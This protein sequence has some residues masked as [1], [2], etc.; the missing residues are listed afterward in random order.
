MKNYRLKYAYWGWREFYA[1][2]VPK[3]G[4]IG[5]LV[6]KL[7]TLSGCD[8]IILVNSGRT[9]IRIALKAFKDQQPN[10]NTVLVPAYTCDAVVQ[11]VVVE[12]FNIKYIDV[13]KNLNMSIDI[14]AEEDFS[15]VLA[16]IAEHNYGYP[17]D[18]NKIAALGKTNDFYVIDDAAQVQ[19]I[20]IDGKPMGSFA[21]AGIYSFAQ[22]KTMVSGLS[23]SGG[24]LM[25]NNPDLVEPFNAISEKLPCAQS[26]TIAAMD[27]IW[28]WVWQ[29]YTRNVTYYFYRIVGW[30]QPPPLG[31]ERMND[32]N[33]SIILSQ[34]DRLDEII[35]GK[36]QAIATYVKIAKEFPK[37]R[38]VQDIENHYIIKLTVLLNAEIK[39]EDVAKELKKQGVQTRLAYSMPW[40]YK[41]P[42]CD[43]A[44]S[45]AE[46][47]IELPMYAGISDD[48]VRDILT[49]FQ[50]VIE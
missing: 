1:S 48:D 14:L 26:S 43:N 22:S 11:A 20:N 21:D 5:E 36:K 31:L 38:F 42:G 7:R 16:V 44:R 4:A 12:G 25:I 9:A 30:T 23:G 6:G 40:C 10:K 47:M 39:P 33:A 29:R 19:G 18:I 34:Y 41:K 27:F 2:V 17:I 24:V 46:N 8:D 37:V 50:K 15:D 49:K 35:D 3:K 13:D 45:T 32:V 28:N